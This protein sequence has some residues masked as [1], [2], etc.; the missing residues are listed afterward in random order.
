MAR[1]VPTPCPQEI[2][3]MSQRPS[4]VAGDE[5]S[6]LFSADGLRRIAESPL[7]DWMMQRGVMLWF[8]LFASMLGVGL[9]N[10]AAG[11]DLAH[12]ARLAWAQLGELLSRF[13]A[14]LFYLLAGWLSLVRAPALAKAPG[15]RPRLTALAAVT[16][17]FALPLLPRLLDPPTWLLFLSAGLAFAGNV[18]A[19]VALN[20]LGTSFSVMSEARK[21]V[22]DGPYR[23][24]RHPIYLAEE[25]AIIGI[26]LP[27][28]S[29]LAA[30]LLVAHLAL[31]LLRLGNEERVLAATLP[32]YADYA[33]RTPRL[34]PG[35]W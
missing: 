5:Q 25:I 35:L 28:W 2:A 18:L 8:L 19:L 7:Y 29:W 10:T 30:L 21:V 27:Y 1:F 9:A 15:L 31:Q 11:I 12:P 33:R 3:R 22:T 6:L 34:V 4:I 17:L 16:V 24:V 14:V 26:F 23:V 32:D 20:R 13:F